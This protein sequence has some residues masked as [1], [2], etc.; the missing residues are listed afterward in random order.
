[1]KHLSPLIFF[2]VITILLFL[3]L[4]NNP[5]IIRSPLLGKKVPNFQLTNISETKQINQE[6]ILGH[7]KLLNV[8]ASWCV[9]CIEEHP[10]LTEINEKELIKIYGVNYK[11]EAGDALG[12]LKIHGNPYEINI[13]DSEGTLSLDLGVYGV[14]ETFLVDKK[15]V[16][17]AKYIG[18][19]NRET[20][21]NE[22]LPLVEKINAE[23]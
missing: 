16:I 17:R 13:F 21:Y 19:L 7:I 12:W 5:N 22:I 23:E 6:S 1:M 3:G 4:S 15:G 10:I 9:A 2:F 11:D 8:W 20:L 18:A 14:P